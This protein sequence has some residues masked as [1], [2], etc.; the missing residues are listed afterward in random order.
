MATDNSAIRYRVGADEEWRDIPRSQCAA[1]LRFLAASRGQRVVWDDMYH[2]L[3][4]SPEVDARLHR[5]RH[6]FGVP[7]ACKMEKA[8][9]RGQFGVYKLGDEV[10]LREPPCAEGRK[11]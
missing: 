4:K 10:Q 6:Q 7:V 11:A 9:G 5:L 2:A 3:G 1:L 8:S